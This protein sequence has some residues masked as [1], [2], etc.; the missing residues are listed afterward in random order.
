MKNPKVVVFGS[1]GQLGRALTSLMPAEPFEFTL[2]SRS[3][4][5]LEAPQK[6]P[7][8]LNQIKPQW[9]IN[10]AAYTDVQR[11]ETEE[12]KAHLINSEAPRMIAQ[13]CAENK[14]AFITYS[15]D[16]VYEGLGNSFQ[17]E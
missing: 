5:N 3:Q 4:A 12:E 7:D 6:I 9:V 16:Y 17:K 1:T 10:A 11:A 2:L 15:T 13:W 14:S 8:I